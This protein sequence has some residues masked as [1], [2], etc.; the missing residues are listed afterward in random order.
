[1]KS[2]AFFLYCFLSC[3]LGFA[4]NADLTGT[5][6][7]FE[8]IIKTNQ[9]QEKTTEQQIKENAFVTDYFLMPDGKFR[10]TSNMTGSGTM[11]T[12]DGTWKYL[13]KKLSFNIKI[14]E[15]NME[16]IWDVEFAG[17]DII[18]KRSSPDGSQVITNSFR[19]KV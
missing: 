17:N 5:W 18:L 10:M 8:V 2:I 6:T 11:D 9:D 3:T 13:D 7:I 16:I 4:Q 19:R 1:M 12:Y 15:R 14:G